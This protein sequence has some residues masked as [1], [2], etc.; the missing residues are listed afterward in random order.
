M[1]NNGKIIETHLAYGGR[2]NI[3]NMPKIGDVV[4][5]SYV[6]GN[7]STHNENKSFI[8]DYANSS[9]EKPVQQQQKEPIKENKRN[10][11]DYIKYFIVVAIAI[12]FFYLGVSIGR[13][14]NPIVSEHLDAT[15]TLLDSVA[16][17]YPSFP[18]TYMCGDEY[19]LYERTLERV[20]NQ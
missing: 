1:R 13:K 15:E 19:A 20:V 16:V 10:D 17:W 11:D 7:G 14:H 6:L 8:V 9:K 18:D 12:V 3:K 2:W 4:V 5:C